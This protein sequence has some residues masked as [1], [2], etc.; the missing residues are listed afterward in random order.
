MKIED[1][2]ENTL[3][4]IS[5]SE[6]IN[7]HWRI[8]Q[9][10][11][12]ARK[13]HNY[14]MNELIEKHQLIV[15]EFI[16][17]GFKHNKINDLDNTVETYDD[18]PS[19]LPDQYVL[20][21]AAPKN[22]ET[23]ILKNKYYPH[24]LT[25]SQIYNY[26]MS[27][28]DKIL[29]YIG[30]RT[31]SFFLMIDGEIIVKRLH[32]GSRIILDSNNYK[33]MITGRTL[34]VHINRFSKTTNYIVIDVDKGQ[35]TSYKKVIDALKTAKHCIDL[36]FKSKGEIVKEEVLFTGSG[37]HYIVYFN[38]SQSIDHMRNIV[39]ECLMDR[40]DK[41]LVN[42]SGRREGTV[43]YDMVSNYENAMHI[44][45]YSLSKEGLKVLIPRSLNPGDYKI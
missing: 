14:D 38:V 25:E 19:S 15:N 22:L 21:E 11:S 37:L 32:K 13:G 1:I 8:H 45:K 40:Q 5:G 36:C 16:R 44:S 6:L 10:W 18:Q 26:Y 7:L 33:E 30:K 34:S 23:I 9:Q 28:K 41:Y 31:V 20:R 43:N 2:T 12:L 29:K 24:G 39:V 42:K 3:K 27:V 4:H 35:D 17:R